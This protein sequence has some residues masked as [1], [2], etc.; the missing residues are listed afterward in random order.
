M[1]SGYSFRPRLR[2]LALAAAACA[3]GI[4][5]GRWQTH[6]AEEKRAAA[7]AEKRLSLRG[8][9][10][11]RYTILLDNRL[12]QGRPGYVVVAPLRLAGQSRCVLVERGWIAAGP[13]RDSPPAVETPAGE[14]TVEGR[15][16]DHL[17]RALD[18][19]KQEREG[20]VRQNV[21]VAGF[22]SW[23]GLTLESYVLEQHSALDD[24]LVR[25]WPRADA[26]AE[27]NEAYALQWYSLA[28]LAVALFL[29]LSVRKK[30]E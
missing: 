9:F 14:Q 26:G 5:L 17:P 16:L 7:A 4:A 18:L 11:A 15:A 1:G 19:G 24:G 3:A 23:S 27:R 22:A 20:Q 12:H 29:V 10:L 25:D 13:R 2:A 6:R 8:E 30:R 21:E 28:A